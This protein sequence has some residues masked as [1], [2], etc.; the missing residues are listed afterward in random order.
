METDE[1]SIWSGAVPGLS[2]KG[3]L[4]RSGSVWSMSMG[5]APMRMGPRADVAALA[6]EWSFQ[7]D[8]VWIDGGAT[9]GHKLLH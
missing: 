2:G 8:V 7:E 3:S 6:P 9:I 1:G 4:A 5:H